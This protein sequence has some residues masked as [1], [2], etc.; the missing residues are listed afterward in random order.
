M[1]IVSARLKTETLLEGALTF[2]QDSPGKI[3]FIVLIYMDALLTLMALSAGMTELNPI[4]KALFE[5]PLQLFAF[6]IAA[7]PYIAWLS[8]TL[9]LLPSIGFMLFVN[10]WNI[11][12]FLLF[13]L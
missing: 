6:K 3:T 1:S 12:E 7:P 2:R 5:N 4:A 9:L 10:A 13:A 11:K 8:P